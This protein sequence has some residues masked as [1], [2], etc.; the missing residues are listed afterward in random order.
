MSPP[1]F[2]K[3]SLKS[4]ER[5]KRLLRVYFC[6]LPFKFVGDSFGRSRRSDEEQ[7]GTQRA[8]RVRHINLWQHRSS[9]TVVAYI[10]GDTD[11]LNPLIIG[12]RLRRSIPVLTQD[13]EPYSLSYRIAVRPISPRHRL[14]DDA[15]VR[16]TTVL[17]VRPDSTGANRHPD[18]RKIFSADFRGYDLL[19]VIRDAGNLDEAP[20]WIDGR[21]RLRASKSD[22]L[23]AWDTDSRTPDPLRI[24]RHFLRSH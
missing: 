23:D 1:V 7:D 10:A 3:P 4:R 8:Y 17:G 12:R 11:N 15:D 18:R 13:G 16:A 19:V 22:R 20:P 5:P 2:P 9:E 6:N 21:R 14:I 24:V